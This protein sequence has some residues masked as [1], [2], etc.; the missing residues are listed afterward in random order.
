MSCLLHLD[1]VLVEE[2]RQRGTLLLV[3]G[4]AEDDELLEQEDPP[5]LHSAERT[6]LW[7]RHQEG[8]L[9]QEATL[10]HNL[11]LRAE[12]GALT[13][14]LDLLSC[15]IGSEYWNFIHQT[16][17]VGPRSSCRYIFLAQCT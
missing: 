1:A 13:E 7:V 3:Q 14:E 6:A 11:P 5:L 12:Q 2:A 4:L 17:A 9:K 10:S 15:R 8:V 16:P